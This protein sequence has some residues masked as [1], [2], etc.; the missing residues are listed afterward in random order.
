VNAYRRIFG[1]VFNADDAAEL[2]YE[3]SCKNENRTRYHGVIH[4]Y[5]RWVRDAAFQQA[6]AEPDSPE[7]VVFMSGGS[8][9]GKSTVAP[10]IAK[11]FPVL[12]YDTTFSILDGA[13]KIIHEVLNAGKKG[14]IIHIHRDMEAAFED[15]LTR[16]RNMLG[17]GRLTSTKSMISTHKGA[18]ETILALAEEFR[19]HPHV[20]HSTFM[21][22]NGSSH[23]E[24]SDAFTDVVREAIRKYGGKPEELV[25]D[26]PQYDRRVDRSYRARPIS[27]L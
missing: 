21:N 22:T 3:Y 17:A 2:F 9:S 24:L 18:T 15:N 23:A 19:E 1:R 7:L 12:V 26:F 27:A 25:R 4:T 10:S 8:A 14:A 16:S 20:T 11:H 6:L 13:R 5:T